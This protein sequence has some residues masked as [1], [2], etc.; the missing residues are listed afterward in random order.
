MSSWSGRRLPR[1]PQ[2]AGSGSVQV[3][4]DEVGGAAHLRPGE[5]RQEPVRLTIIRHP[6]VPG[7]AAGSSAQ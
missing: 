7:S 6:D 4:G 5:R 1:Q 2:S 3:G